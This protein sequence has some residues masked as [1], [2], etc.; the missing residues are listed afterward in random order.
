MMKILSAYPDFGY[1]AEINTVFTSSDFTSFSDFTQEYSTI[2]VTSFLSAFL[3]LKYLQR[4]V[5]YSEYSN[6]GK[7]QQKLLGN[8]NIAFETSS[9][10][11]SPTQNYMLNLLI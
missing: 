10:V 11:N 2:I 8:I 3:L 4:S 7:W 9:E 1:T 6:T 5:A